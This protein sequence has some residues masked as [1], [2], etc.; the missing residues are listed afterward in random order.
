MIVDTS[1]VTLGDKKMRL[2]VLLAVPLL[3][4]ACNTTAGIGRDLK[5][6]GSAIED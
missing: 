5:S 2:L 3:L 6:A 4:A 1:Y